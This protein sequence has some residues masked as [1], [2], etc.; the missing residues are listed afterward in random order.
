MFIN[1]NGKLLRTGDAVLPVH[2]SSY[3]YGD[4]LFETLRLMNGSIPLRDAHFDRLF[5]GME[6]LGYAI[7]VLLTPDALEKQVLKLA[8]KNNLSSARI[9][10]SVYRGAGGLFDNDQKPGYL[11]ES[12]ALPDPRFTLNHNGL[13]IGVC[14]DVRKSVDRY[15]SLKTASAL[16]YT[17]AAQY[18]K[19]QR[20]NDALVLNADGGIADTTIANLFVIKQNTIYVPSPDQGGVAGVMRSWL[21]PRLAADGYMVVEQRLEPS[22]LADAD[23]VFLTNAVRGLRWVERFDSFRYGNL[24]AQEIFT[25]HLATIGA[26]AC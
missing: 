8:A 24:R 19:A 7:P 15:A 13:V 21:L 23:E 16:C 3:R 14:E 10:L 9:R 2:N 5:R 25:R 12:W 26:P 17:M 4:G 18:A 1:F 22:F 20:W 6:T 11:I